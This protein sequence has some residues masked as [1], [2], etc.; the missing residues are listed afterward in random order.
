M[1]AAAATPEALA[2]LLELLGDRGA[3][4]AEG[5]FLVEQARVSGSD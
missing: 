2:R 3:W 4:A 5:R 1:G